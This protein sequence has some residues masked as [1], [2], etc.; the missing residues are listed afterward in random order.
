DHKLWEQLLELGVT[1]M[2]VPEEQGGDGVGI[3]ELVIIAEEFGR[4][5]APVPLLEHIVAT[6]LLARASD[7]AVGELLTAA[8]AGTRILGLAAEPLKSRQLVSTAAVTQDVVG[9]DG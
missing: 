8:I 3:S 6:R 1:Q 2:G 5:L 9:F 4:V 7:D